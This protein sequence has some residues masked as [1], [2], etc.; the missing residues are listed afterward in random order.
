MLA[1][2]RT[3][4]FVDSNIWLYAFINTSDPKKLTAA[5]QVIRTTDSVVTPQV[6]NEVCHNLLKKAAWTESQVGTLID[7]FFDDVEVIA[8]DRTLL[9]SA[10]QLR[11]LLSLSFWDSL[12]VAGALQSGVSVLYSEDLQHGLVVDSTLT[13]SNPFAGS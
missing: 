12:I 4:A 2:N 11:G 9:L 8:F 1:S 5:Q 10:S 6:V 7:S 3:R 13:I